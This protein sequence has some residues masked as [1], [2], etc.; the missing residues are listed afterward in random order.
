MAIKIY[1]PTTPGRRNASGIDYSVLT[2]KEPEKSLL[3]PLKKSGGRNSSG[4]I[5][6]RHRG[7]GA[8]RM[9]RVVDFKRNKENIPAKVAAL[10]YDPNRTAFIALLH[11]ADGEK[12]YIIAP[13][14][15]KVG[16]TIMSGSKA[17]VKLG[18][19]LPLH[20]IPV[21]TEVSCIEI[22]PGKG[23]Q[24]VRSA[25]TFAVVK[26]VD[27]DKVHLQLASSEI[28][29]F[30]PQ[31]KAMVGRVSN[32]DWHNIKL[33]KAG[34]KRWMG[35]RPTVRGVAQHPGSHPHGGGEGRSGIGM[36]SP[37]T[38]WGKKTLGKKT[39]KT[40]K[41]SDKIIVQRRKK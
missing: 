26:S 17:E 36:P 12:R 40:K 24:L 16:D 20:K 8:K 25:G 37:K 39:R 23:A 28:R 9:Y 21:G 4:H 5:T 22:R 41:Y 35:I 31:A 14:G 3:R 13:E 18:N 6:I 19:W 33:G 32:P 29:A 2:K 30:S 15:L 38:P 27:E 11:Y 34:R 1:K 10:E 7:G